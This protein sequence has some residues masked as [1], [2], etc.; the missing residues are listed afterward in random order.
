MKYRLSLLAIA[1]FV[2]GSIGAETIPWRHNYTAACQEARQ[3][4]RPILIDVGA[5]W[6]AWCKKLDATS[7]RDPEV[8][9]RVAGSYVAFHLDADKQEALVQK[10]QI[11]SF[12]TLL[13]V[14]ADGKILGRR[15][16]YVGAVELKNWLERWASVSSRTAS[17]GCN[18]EDC[19][20]L[21]FYVVMAGL[22]QDERP[23]EAREYLLKALAIHGGAHIR[24]EIEEK[25]RLLGDRE[26]R[27]LAPDRTR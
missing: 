19:R 15:E 9:R 16:G 3:T 24:N 10:F 11:S 22:L 13:V 4:N 23:A 7:F 27:P 12:P 8:V 2:Q 21:E 25:L 6:C 5:E 26:Q 1:A 14:S 20:R 17:G 18:D